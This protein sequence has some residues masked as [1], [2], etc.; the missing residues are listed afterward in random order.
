MS[1]DQYHTESILS[2]ISAQVAALQSLT[3][4]AFDCQGL[5]RT[6][7]FTFLLTFFFFLLMCLND[8]LLE[9]ENLLGYSCSMHPKMFDQPF[10][11]YGSHLRTP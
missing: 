4:Q 5:K 3:I 8:W 10:S 2:F 6:A 9:S 1:D 11:V 7:I